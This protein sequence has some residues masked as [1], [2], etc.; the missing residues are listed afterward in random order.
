M[1]VYNYFLLTFGQ[2]KHKQLELCLI[3][4]SPFIKKTQEKV[5]SLLFYE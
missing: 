2:I 3:L 5:M 1:F 4:Q